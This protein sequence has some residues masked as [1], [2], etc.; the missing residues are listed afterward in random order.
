MDDTQRKYDISIEAFNLAVKEAVYR[1][2]LRI[3]QQFV[4]QLNAYKSLCRVL[5]IVL[6]VVTLCSV[7]LNIK[8]LCGNLPAL[9]ALPALPHSTMVI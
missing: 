4:E 6:S 9:P 7:L 1:A 8:L 5:I 3:R 2:E